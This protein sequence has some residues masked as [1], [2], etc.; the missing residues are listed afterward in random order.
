MQS[1]E[2]GQASGASAYPHESQPAQPDS[3]NAATPGAGDSSLLYP[4]IVESLVQQHFQ[5]P[6]GSTVPDPPAQDISTPA[7]DWTSNMVSAI[8][9][10]QP[11]SIAFDDE[12]LNSLFPIFPGDYI[13]SPSIDF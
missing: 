9:W 13:F 12:D 8:N 2:A 5:Y 11:D 3:N 7:L 4:A 10:L 1:T 6:Q